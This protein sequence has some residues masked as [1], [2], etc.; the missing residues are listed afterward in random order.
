MTTP[1]GTI[2]ASDIAN[3]FGYSR[4]NNSV[5]LGAY[6]IKQ[7]IGDREW[8]LDTGVPTDTNSSIGFSQLR[9]KTLNVVVD[10]PPGAD[11]ANLDV[12][13]YYTSGVVVGGLKALP[14]R[15]GT[16]QGKK[17]YNL[18]RKTIFG[19][20][21]G[22]ASLNTG[23]WDSSAASVNFIITSTGLVL[24]RGGNGGNGANTDQVG[25]DGGGGSPAIVVNYT[26]NI[27]VEAGGYVAGGGGGAGGGGYSYNGGPDSRGGGGGGGGG[28][29]YVGGSGGP[30][31][32]GSGSGQGNNQCGGNGGAGSIFGP[33]GGAGGGDTGGG[34][35]G[36][37]GG[38][39]G[40]FGQPGNTGGSGGNTRGGYGGPAGAAI[41]QN[42][43]AN[44]TAAS[45]T[46]GI[47]YTPGPVKNISTGSAYYTQ[48]R[49]SST[50][51]VWVNGGRNGGYYT[52]VTV[53]NAAAATA[54]TA[55]TFNN[56]SPTTI[57][58]T[59]SGLKVNVSRTVG[60]TTNVGAGGGFFVTCGT[61]YY[62]A[63]YTLTVVNGGTGYIPFTSVI[64]INVD[65]YNV[66]MVVY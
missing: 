10:F 44:I 49:T 20:I 4:A 28:Q 8:P 13:N 22:A 2:K 12:T 31:G 11:A 41:Q 18:I 1:T 23:T 40:T 29:G 34:P 52:N 66:D 27:T 50:K 26:S 39:G 64:R 3:E 30:R 54:W 42:V 62:Y 35:N 65:G 32:C 59:G 21:A 7:F 6:R 37:T 58:G 17:V 45:I 51:Q 46:S 61:D 5:S 15:T 25:G 14:P 24:G 33:G 9:G 56:I 47:V 57:A 38:T 48:A 19:N 60:G 63:N 43:A 36:G 55:A 53:C 16:T